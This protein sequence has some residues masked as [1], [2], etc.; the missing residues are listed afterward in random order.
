M[1]MIYATIAGKAAVLPL[2]LCIALCAAARPPERQKVKYTPEEIVRLRAEAHRKMLERTGGYVMKPGVGKGTVV[3]FNVQTRV[4]ESNI[5]KVASSLVRSLRIKVAVERVEGVVTPADAGTRLKK[6]G[7]AAGVFLV[8][9]AA[10]PS[11]LLV[12]PE[13]H[14]SIVNV[15]ALAAD[16]A[17][18]PFVVARTQKEAM[19][20]F[21]FAFNA[22]DSQSE[23]SLMGPIAAP[24]ELDL[25]PG[26]RPPVDVL[27]RAI[28]AMPKY[29]VERWERYTYRDAC[30]EGWAP[31]PTNEY[32]KAVWD[33]V[34]ALP[35]EP[36][37]ITPETKKTA[38]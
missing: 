28:R 15:A 23:D 17:A 14:W 24:K 4:A 19:R 26:A 2:V 3:F 35:T 12:A 32:Q 1:K 33:K 31:A 9:D 20:A 37:K 7:A 30:Q 34:H 5:V 21:L 29:G 16:G 8:D 27:N 38:K 10:N 13:G 18:E 36:I 25:F 11:T 6:S 22:G